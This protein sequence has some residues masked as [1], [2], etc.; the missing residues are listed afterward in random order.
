M[1]IRT[2]NFSQ[3]HERSYY[4]SLR[5]VF[6]HAF[7]FYS[8]FILFV[9]PTGTGIRHALFMIPFFAGFLGLLLLKHKISLFDFLLSGILLISSF[10][11]GHYDTITDA[12]VFSMLLLFVSL[13]YQRRELSIHFNYGLILLFCWLFF[14][15]L[16]YQL[17]QNFGT[18]GY[19]EY[20][21]K[22]YVGDTNFSGLYML[23]FLFFSVRC[24][25]WPGIVLS[26]IS[27][28]LFL[29]RTYFLALTVFFLLMYFRDFLAPLVRRL[30]FFVI[31]MTLNI[32]LLVY[33]FFV[34][35]QMGVSDFSVRGF[36]RLFS[37][38]DRSALVRLEFNYI[39]FYRFINDPIFLFV[40]E[41]QRFGEIARGLLGN[42][43]HNTLFNS[44]GTNGLFFSVMYLW[45]LSVIFK[46]IDWVSNFAYIIPVIFYSLF[47]HGI[48]NQGFAI[49]LVLILMIPSKK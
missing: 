20:T 8:G 49:F 40:G 5:D 28:L 3:L 37:F 31:I 24:K 6:Y 42:V 14:F 44:V 23:L 9:L 21:S 22:L 47:L 36:E 16:V 10:L 45:V 29:S 46:K 48:F 32:L 1:S 13:A 30:N 26:L 39:L 15:S 35:T 12:I 2:E 33:A 25:F 19:W 18:F 27:V 11:T 4:I 17:I 38:N 7:L 43:P 34:V 41:G